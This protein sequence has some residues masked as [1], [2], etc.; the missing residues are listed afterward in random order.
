MTDRSAELDRDILLRALK[1]QLAR[2]ERFATAQGFTEREVES[3]TM[4]DW[5][6]IN[7]I[8]LGMT[9]PEGVTK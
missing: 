8:E 6:L 9:E 3:I 4:G 5:A 7:R 2:V 1:D